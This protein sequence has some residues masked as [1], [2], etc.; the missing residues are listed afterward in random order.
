MLT[1]ATYIGFR[2]YRYSPVT[3]NWRVGKIGAGVPKPCTA[4]HANE[5]SR[6]IVPK[7]IST[8]PAS[9]R[10]D[11]PNKAGLSCQ[12]EIHHGT[13]P[14][15]NPGAMTRKI[16][17]PVIAESFLSLPSCN[18]VSQPRAMENGPCARVTC[19]NEVRGRTR[20]STGQPSRHCIP[21]TG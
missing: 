2:T 3:T 16:A 9:R 12:R 4:K 19:Q 18:Q 5:S 17:D 20:T 15:T 11:N 7:A 21:C 6:P 13:K 10:N 8:P 14:T 1:T